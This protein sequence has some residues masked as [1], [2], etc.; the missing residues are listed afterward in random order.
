[1]K[2]IPLRSGDEMDAFSTY[3]KYHRWGRGALKKIKRGYNKRMRKHNKQN[4]DKQ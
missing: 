3:R 4:K 2:R 1:M